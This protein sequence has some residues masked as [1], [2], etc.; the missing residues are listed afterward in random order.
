MS[1]I[2]FEWDKLKAV[3]N[4]RKHGISFEEAQTVFYDDNAVLFDDPDHSQ[5]EDRFIMLGMSYRLRVLVISHCEKHGDIIRII[6]ARKAARHEAQY[7]AE[8][9]I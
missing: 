9:K 5:R 4:K 8:G 3:A 7:Y 6:S 2:R 1:E